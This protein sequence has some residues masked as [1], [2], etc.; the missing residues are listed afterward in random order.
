[1][2]SVDPVDVNNHINHGDVEESKQK[3]EKLKE[4]ANQFFKGKIS[5]RFLSNK[6][7][8]VNAVC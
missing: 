5:L 4:E 2:S 6:H 3:A 1:M 7:T 8:P